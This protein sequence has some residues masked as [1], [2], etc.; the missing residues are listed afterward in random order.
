MKI[1]GRAYA[2]TAMFSQNTNSFAQGLDANNGTE[3][4]A[5]WLY[6]A[7]TG[8][9]VIDYKVQ[10]DLAGNVSY[11]DVFLAVKELPLLGH[12]K[13]GHFK[14]PF[15]LEQ[16]TAS[17][18]LTFMERSLGDSIFVPAR[19]MGVMAYDCSES[20]R[21]TWA[22]GAFVSEQGADPPDFQR[23]HEGAALTMR[24][25]YLPWYDEATNGRGLFH[26]GAAYSYRAISDGQV[27]LRSRP[28]SHLAPYIVDTTLNVSDVQL[29]GGELAYVYGS[30]SAQAEYFHATLDPTAA[31]SDV[32]LD[33]CYFL[34][35]YFLTGENRPYSRQS[36]AFTR[37]KPFENFFRV[38]DEN[39]DVQMGKGALELAYRYSYVDLNDGIAAGGRGS[40]HTL[41]LNWYL[42]PYTRMMFNY[43]HSTADTTAA[44]DGVMNIFQMRAQFDF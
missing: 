38:R 42:T 18:Y 36:G 19:N 37:V 20:E 32:E 10:F 34:C 15:S 22:M 8:F 11:K 25:T 29:F 41:G 13:I 30:F 28:E 12:V 23:D 3:F 16:L 1:G 9:D 33:G 40:D 35:S 21:M 39:G 4:R 7:G 14:E 24:A 43:I 31:G 26:T 27:R 6:F 5:T 2:D 44:N 17:K